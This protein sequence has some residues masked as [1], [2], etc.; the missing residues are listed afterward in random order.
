MTSREI[1]G[2][3]IVS[4]L[5]QITCTIDATDFLKI[6]PQ[7]PA[8]LLSNHTSNIEGPIIYINLRPR[9]ATAI[10]K[11][12]LWKN[13]ITRFLMNAW[14]VIPVR[15]GEI[16]RATLRACFQALDNGYIL[17]VAPEG[18]RS[19]SG[20]LRT[21]QPGATYLATHSKAPIIPMVQW[22]LQH[23][24]RNIRKLRKTRIHFKIG[25]PFYLSQPD[26]SKI[27]PSDRK[28]MTEEMM[29]RLAA[30]LPPALRGRYADVSAATTKYITFTTFDEISPSA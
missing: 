2:N 1:I 10:A 19:R 6:P 17:G 9:R 8:I 25:Q 30:L 12:E 24:S 3:A 29:Y 20:I 5:A 7:G 21:G 4:L 26:G 11:I 22:G 13:P 14:E 23:F 18:T 27:S 28:A 16:N 15:R